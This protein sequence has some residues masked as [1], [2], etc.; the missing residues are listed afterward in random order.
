MSRNASSERPV[1]GAWDW[2]LLG[3]TALLMGFGLLMILSASSTYADSIY[4]NALTFVN[5]QVAGLGLGLVLGLVVLLLPWRTLRAA[6]W[7]A[8]G[9]G[10]VSLVLVFSPLGHEVNGATRWI[11]LGVNIQPSEF[12]KLALVMVLADY[13]ARNEGRLRDPAVPLMAGL[14]ASP[15]L[16]L[17]MVQPDFGTT[18][19]LV[20]LVGVLLFV[21]GLE[22]KWVG[23]LGGVAVAGLGF[24]A[25]LEPYRLARL[26]S[27]GDPFVDSS[28]D[29]YQVIQG[30]IALASGGLTGQGLATGVAQ[31]GFLPEAHTDFVAAVVAEEL[32]AIGL[33]ILVLAYGVLVWR[34]MVIASRAPDLYGTLLASAITSLL[35]VQ[36][37]INLGVV[38]GLMPAKGLV[39]PFLSYGASAAVVHTLGVAVLLRVSMETRAR[40]GVNQEQAAA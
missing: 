19:I 24:M 39:L 16:I 12:A 27:F 3:T 15:I 11:H 6:G 29:G 37:A 2:P 13:L 17:V 33:V 18:V 30:W 22:W 8:F 5:R 32:G 40:E 23:A 34:G 7:P 4:A 35:G 36:A 25:I 14:V 26:R 21:A 1:L 9:V 10:I 20:G 38:M 31:R 28:G